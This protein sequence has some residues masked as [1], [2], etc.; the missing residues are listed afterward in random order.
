MT[1]YLTWKILKKAGVLR[2]IRKNKFLK[3]SYHELD[4]Y[5]NY[6]ALEGETS[7]LKTEYL[8]VFPKSIINK[9]DSPDIGFSYSINPY[10]GCEHGCIYCYARV[11]HQ[12]WGYSAGLDFEQKVLVKK[13]AA[14]LLDKQLTSKNWRPELIML[15]GNTDCYQPIERKLKITRALLEVFNKRKHP[16]GIITKNKLICRDLDILT[17]LNKDNLLR[18]TL[19]I[20]T[21]DDKL[22]MLLEPRTASVNQR[23]KTLKK[24]TDAGIKVNVNMAPIIPGLN[25]HEILE[26][27]EKVSSLGAYSM[28]YIMV[29]LNGEIGPIFEDWVSKTYPLKKD[30]ILNQ[31]RSTHQGRLNDSRFK[32]RMKGDGK[33]AE[34]VA[35]LFKIAKAKYFQNESL[36][37][38]NIEL[39]QKYRSNQIKLF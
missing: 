19:S 35:Q 6:V 31:I 23:L 4:D 26:L 2:P 16:V 36:P 3:D 32:T 12:Y 34:Q 38:P 5:K 27:A 11:T 17:Q 25:S 18:V 22:R 15:S 8:E 39:Y 24:L 21:L 14:K 9:V 37:A 1:K 28:M 30:K 7:K 10:Q 13:N 20:T 33:I 29:R